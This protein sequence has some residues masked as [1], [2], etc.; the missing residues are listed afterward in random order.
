M[1]IMSTVVGILLPALTRARRR[2]RKITGVNNLQ[3]IAT[4]VNCYSL[5][6]EERYPDSVA[7]IGHGTNWNWQEPFVLT[8]IRSRA[9]GY[10]RSVSEY[11]HS[12][13]PDG[14]IMICPNGPKKYKYLRQAWDAG[15]NWDNPDSPYKGNDWVKGLYCFYW[16]YVGLVERSRLFIGPRTN[17]GAMGES[18]LL[19]SC[20]FGYGRYQSPYS[21]GSCEQIKAAYV[22]QEKIPTARYWYHIETENFNLDSIN[23]KPNAVYTDGH[24]E[25]FSPSQVVPMEIIVDR[26]ANK[27]Y[28]PGPWSPGIFYLP[29]KAM[30]K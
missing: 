11:L 14:D 27:P 8:S 25:S 16:N 19:A 4:A 7:T 21:Y 12:Y 20:Y 29:E 24:V 5:S 2:A 9:I 18:K 26:L 3:Q 13:I 22:T 23:I 28:K 30:P 17:F 15:D 10:H 6:N 1:F